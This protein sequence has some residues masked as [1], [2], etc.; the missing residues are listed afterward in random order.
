MQNDWR[1]WLQRARLYAIIDTGYLRERSVTFYAKELVKG[2]VHVIQLRA[3]KESL[4][5]VETMAK[6][7]HEI[8][9]EAKIPLILNDYVELAVKL[10][11]EGVHVGQQDMPLHEVRKKMPAPAILG[12]STHSLNQAMAAQQEK[13]DYIGFGPLFATPT[14]PTYQPIGIDLVQHVHQQVDIPIFC[15]G[16]VKFENLKTILQAGAKRV[17]AVS[18]IMQADSPSDYCLELNE[19]LSQF[20]LLS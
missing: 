17:V 4:Q 10:N 15:I 14:K 12:K 5:Q 8:T 11:L 20:P 18:G 19:I 9:Q 13:P 6:A 16:G 2:G 3:K 7:V 1:P